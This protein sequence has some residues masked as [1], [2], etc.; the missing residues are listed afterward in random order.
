MQVYHFPK[1][2]QRSLEAEVNN[3]TNRNKKAL[4]LVSLTIREAGG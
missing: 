4:K 1:T 2:P 3:K